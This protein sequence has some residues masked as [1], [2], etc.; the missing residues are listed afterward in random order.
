MDRAAYISQILTYNMATQVPST[1]SNQVNDYE[2]RLERN[3]EDVKSGKLIK[4]EEP[5]E[6]NV[7]DFNNKTELEFDSV[8]LNPDNENLLHRNSTTTL[9]QN[10]FHS[11][12]E[13]L[14]VLSYV[15][16]VSTRMCAFVL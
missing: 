10:P 16:S 8:Y 2:V 1:L 3:S 13:A 4:K 9:L 7:E 5:T 12:S 6:N 14:D 11:S 15:A